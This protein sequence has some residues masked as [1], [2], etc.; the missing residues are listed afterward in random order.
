MS[1]INIQNRV[2]TLV[3]AEIAS[4]RDGSRCPYRT[5]RRLSLTYNSFFQLR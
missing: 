2:G 5:A 4:K 1:E 3:M